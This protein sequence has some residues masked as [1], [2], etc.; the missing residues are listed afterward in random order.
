[1]QRP[2]A[3]RRPSAGYGVGLT[4]ESYRTGPYRRTPSGQGHLR[5]EHALR[6]PAPSRDAAAVLTLVFKVPIERAEI[7]VWVA[8]VLN[9]RFQR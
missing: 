2:R 9:L 6:N 3:S 5:S 8:V 4:A 1:M 7:V